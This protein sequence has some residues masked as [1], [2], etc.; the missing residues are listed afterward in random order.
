MSIESPKRL[1]PGWVWA[2]LTVV[3]IALVVVLFFTD[4]RKTPDTSFEYDL[5]S[6]TQIDPKEVIFKEAGRIPL[7]VANP[8]AMAI[9]PDGKIYVGGE[10]AVIVL[11]DEGKELARYAVKGTPG[12]LAAI[13]DGKLLAGMKNHIEV[14]DAQ[15]SSVATWQDLGEH[16]WLTSIA[17]NDQNVYAADAGNRIVL[18][19]DLNGT[20]QTRIGAADTA[21]NIPG[22]VV[23]SAFLDVAFDPMDALW[24]VNPGKHGLENYRANGDLVS[25]WYRMGMDLPGFC[26]C[27]NPTHIAFRSDGTLVTVEKGLNRVKLYAPDTSLLGVV[28]PPEGLL[29][30]GSATMS[31]DLEPPV[32]DLA[33]DAKDRVLVL[34]NPKHVILVFEKIPNREGEAPAKP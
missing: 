8:S 17:V 3:V 15:G 12:C 20:L 16:A 11:N 25:S 1:I 19:Y 21:R 13:P 32:R 29:A 6:Y 7:N 22:L 27:C 5:S 34:N 23:P 18:R 9:G 33:V 26:G 31:C 4:R 14:L 2:A 30:P 24:V 28:A 10:N